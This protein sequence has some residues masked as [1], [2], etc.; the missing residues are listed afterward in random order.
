M[1]MALGMDRG[2]VASAMVAG[3][4]SKALLKLANHI[5][6][7]PYTDAASFFFLTNDPMVDG[8]KISHPAMIKT[9]LRMVWKVMEMA[10][11]V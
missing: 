9:I 2:R 11:V 10:E 6:R 3:L 1:R 5:P 4:G 7:R 8:E